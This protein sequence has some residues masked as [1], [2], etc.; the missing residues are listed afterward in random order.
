MLKQL[1]A[2][3][4]VIYC[5]LL[6]DTAFAAVKKTPARLQ[7][8]SST[9]VVKGFND[10]A[11]NK[12]HSSESFNYEGPGLSEPSAW[13]R[14][15][16]WFWNTLFRKVGGP[17]IGNILKYGFVALAIGL[18]VFIIF[19]LTGMDGMRLWQ[20]Q[21]RK[22]NLAYTESLENI[23]EIDFDTELEKAIA[24][25]NYRLA[26]RLLYLKCLKQLND[27][28]LIRWQI[29]KTNSIYVYELNDPSLRQAFLL[30][31]RQFEY[32]WYGGF[33]V[34]G[35]AFKSINQLFQNFKKQLA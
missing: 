30:L 31:T 6:C 34:D 19:K 11:L 20:G 2:F 18:L 33:T 3:L 17:V 4:L 14:F 35:D 25:H 22:A 1:F 7:K 29:D 21:V 27:E 26:V 9:V 5:F 10:K 12:Y 23:H 15:W 32:V 13:D 16:A 24:L 8:D 28:E